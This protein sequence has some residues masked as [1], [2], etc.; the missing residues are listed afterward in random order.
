MSTDPAGF[1]IVVRPSGAVRWLRMAMLGLGLA[2]FVLAAWLSRGQDDRW[3]ILG[4]G[5]LI[6][7]MGWRHASTGLSWGTLRVMADGQVGW[8]TGVAD[9]PGGPGSGVPAFL[10]ARV[11]RWHV[12]ENLIW[13]RLRTGDGRRHEV[14]VGRTGQC[15]EDW[16]RLHGW[17]AWLK[18]GRS[19]D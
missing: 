18:R 3:L 4:F 6:L 16:R 2:G 14:L 12:G 5:I 1:E 7:W 13:M 10:A 19:A 8:R 17:L 15:P 9:S 11:L